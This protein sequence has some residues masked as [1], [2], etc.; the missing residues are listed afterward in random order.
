MFMPG[1][2]CPT[3]VLLTHPFSS[4]SPHSFTAAPCHCNQDFSLLILQPLGALK[5]SL[6]LPGIFFSML[7][8]FVFVGEITRLFMHYVRI[9][10]N[11]LLFFSDFFL[12]SVFKSVLC[13]LLVLG[14]WAVTHLFFASISS[15]KWG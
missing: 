7:V 8:D 10:L 9:C 3:W 15:V 14:S 2:Q 5:R 1:A 11:L 6:G 4:L 12:P 13:H